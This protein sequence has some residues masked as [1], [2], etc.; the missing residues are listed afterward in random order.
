VCIGD[1]LELTCTTTADSLQWRFSVIRGN[2]TAA[3]EFRRTIRST[4][5]DLSQLEVNSIMFNFSRTT[6][7]GSV[8]VRSILSIG[9]ISNS[10]NGTM[11]HCVTSEM[12][13][14]AIIQR[15][16]IQGMIHELAG[17][18]PAEGDPS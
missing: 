11:I 13:L 16:S 3:T 10:L 5:S 18:H 15:Y 7:H 14:T 8:P 1:Q 12:S 17:F 4:G 9:P 2:E 6:S